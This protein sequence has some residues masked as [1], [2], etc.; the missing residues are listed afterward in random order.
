MPRSASFGQKTGEF[1]QPASFEKAEPLAP[2]FQEAHRDYVPL[3]LEDGDG[4]QMVK[5]DGQFHELRPDPE[6][7]SEQDRETF[8]SKWQQELDSAAQRALDRYISD[9]SA[10]QDNDRDRSRDRDSELSL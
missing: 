1:D 6:I 7:A 3:E 9:D 8:D 2:E 10:E 5:D 4:S